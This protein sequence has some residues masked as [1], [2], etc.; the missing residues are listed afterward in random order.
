[1]ANI[2]AT[3]LIPVWSGIWLWESLSPRLGLT[4]RFKVGGHDV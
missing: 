2:A 1:M 3:G 4:D